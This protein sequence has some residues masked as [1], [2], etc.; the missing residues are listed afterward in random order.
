V[1]EHCHFSGQFRGAAHSKC[2]LLFRKPKHVP[3]IFRKLSGYDSHLFIQSLGK[4]R[5]K[6]DCISNSEEKYI[7]FSKSVMLDG[8]FKSKIR[9]IDS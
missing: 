9:F 3:V 5:E 7:S 1:R 8:K 2:N 6:I 4:T